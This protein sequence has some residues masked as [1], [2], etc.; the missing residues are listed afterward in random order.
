MADI[1]KF[2]QGEEYY[3]VD[4]NSGAVHIVDE[5]V[6]DLLNDEGLKK[7]EDLVIEFKDK[8]EEKEIREAYNELEELIKE[9]ILYS[10]DLYEGYSF[11]YR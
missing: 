8:H 5:L 3:V 10:K 1:H 4:I 7:I 9:G 2:K 11:S 6:Y